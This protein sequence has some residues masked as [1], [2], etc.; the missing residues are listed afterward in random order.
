MSKARGPRKNT[1]KPNRPLDPLLACGLKRGMRGQMFKEATSS[2][3]TVKGFSVGNYVT[4]GTAVSGTTTLS[5]IFGISPPSNETITGVAYDKTGNLWITFA[6]SANCPPSSGSAASSKIVEYSANSLANGAP[7][8]TGQSISVSNGNVAGI[9]FDSSGNLWTTVGCLSN[10]SNSGTVSMYPILSGGTISTTPT[11]SI[12]NQYGP[13]NSSTGYQPV[14]V[15]FDFSGNLWI[16]N[17]NSG[18]ASGPFLVYAA[19]EIPPK[20]TTQPTAPFMIMNVTVGSDAQLVQGA[21]FDRHG[22]LWSG[23]ICSNVNRIN[24]SQP[25]SHVIEFQ[26]ATL[27]NL[28]ATGGTVTKSPDYSFQAPGTV[29][30]PSGYAYTSNDTYFAGGAEFDSGGNLWVAIGAL[31]NSTG[32]LDLSAQTFFFQYSSS[33]L[34][35]SNPTPIN[36]FPLTPGSVGFSAFW[37]IPNGLPVY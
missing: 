37:P 13:N 27:S 2:G 11:Y 5:D 20:S 8:E 32:S 7:A 21:S 18:S 24:C 36:E 12:T 22:N 23:V 26:S 4:A 17:T 34:G 1:A 14:S 10:I 16:S 28:M 15:F 3:T 31:S 19:S 35:N 6:A 30:A 25:Y 33:S 9:A 29:A